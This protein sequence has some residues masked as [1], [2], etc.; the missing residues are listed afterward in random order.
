M[1]IQAF[2]AN[3]LT[4]ATLQLVSV[5]RSTVFKTDHYS[6]LT[7]F[8]GD[9]DGGGDRCSRD[10]LYVQAPE[11]LFQIVSM[12]TVDSDVVPTENAGLLSTYRGLQ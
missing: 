12:Q 3:C 2:V 7:M 9:N 11:R 4:T 8:P 1:Q 6:R 10:D 5:W